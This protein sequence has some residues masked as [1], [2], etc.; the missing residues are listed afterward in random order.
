MLRIRK[1][2]TMRAMSRGTRRGSPPKD[3]EDGSQST[4]RK[5]TVDLE[6][7]AAGVDAVVVDAGGG[8]KTTARLRPLA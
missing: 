5:L 1:T 8:S 2:A 4:T 6:T 3:M 7:V